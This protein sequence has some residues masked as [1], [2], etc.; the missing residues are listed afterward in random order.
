[1]L[2]SSSC[3]CQ[4]CGLN[5][6]KK[7]N[8]CVLINLFPLQIKSVALGDIICYIF[9]KLRIA[10]SNMYVTYTVLILSVCFL[11][12]VTMSVL[13]LVWGFFSSYTLFIIHINENLI[14]YVYDI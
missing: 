1:M 5:V 2:S 13:H 9:N 4:A 3:S 10:G 8:K 12:L 7:K 6:Q 14:V 11:W